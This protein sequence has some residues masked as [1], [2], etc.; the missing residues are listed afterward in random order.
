RVS[1]GGAQ[2]AFGVQPDLSSFAKIV[3]GGLPG[4]AVA[5]RRDILEL[6]D[7]AAAEKSGREKIQHPGTFNAN[8][9][10]AAAGTAA[11]TLIAETNAC[12][13]AS[14]AAAVLRDELNAVLEQERVPWA[15]YGTYSGFHT[16]MNTQGRALRPSRF[17]PTKFGMEELKA[18]PKT[19]VNRMRLALLVHG[20][21][22]GSRI[23]GFLSATHTADDIEHTVDAFRQ[24]VRMLKQEG[25]LPA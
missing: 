15:I 5:G 25:E 14:R 17:D 22:V 7:F 18:Q 21:D 8:P 9:V 13:E 11:L 12:D 2:V 6:L 1:R 10:S 19:L 23:G 20:V 3:A 4:A 24:S 16:F